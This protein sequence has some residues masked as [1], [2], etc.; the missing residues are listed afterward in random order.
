MS[1]KPEQIDVAEVYALLAQH[2]LRWIDT[3]NTQLAGSGFQRSA[4]EQTQDQAV[5][6]LA[7][8]LL[9]GPPKVMVEVGDGAVSSVISAIPV[10]LLVVDYDVDSVDEEVLTKVPDGEGGSDMAQL[11][12]MPVRP[13]TPR[14]LERMQAV[15]EAA[16][17]DQ[18]EDQHTS[19]HRP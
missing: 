9:E 13:S 17:T 10:R 15:F 5:Q 11:I 6:A 14:Q 3:R 16:E 12:E 4:F 19:G 7:Q 2:A 1:E 18:D 8:C